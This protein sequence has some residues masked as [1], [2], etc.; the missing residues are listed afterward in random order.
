MND[1]IAV[2]RKSRKLVMYTLRMVRQSLERD[3]L[4]GQPIDLSA[5]QSVLE[6]TM[7]VAYLKGVRRVQLATKMTSFSQLDSLLAY[8]KR[9]TDVENIDALQSRL[10]TKALRIVSEVETTVEKKLREAIDFT[11]PIRAQKKQ[12]AKAFKAAGLSPSS[13]G[14]LETIVRTQTQIAYSAARWEAEQAPEI[15]EILWGYEYNTVGDNRVRPDH[16]ELDGVTLPKEDSF[17]R[18]FYPPNGYNCRCVAIPLFEA[19]K[20]ISKPPARPVVDS[21]FMFNPGDLLDV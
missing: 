14:M 9:F 2:D 5:L 4:R 19:P 12:L 17:W 15:Q 7:L 13:A 8:M 18:L 20:T 11:I 10:R 3:L 1:T 16:A 21:N 6:K